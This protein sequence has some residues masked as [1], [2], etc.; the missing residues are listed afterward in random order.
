MSF[1]NPY[2]ASRLTLDSTASINSG[3]VA[4]YPL[5]DETSSTALDISGNYH[6]GTMTNGAYFTGSTGIGR[7][8]FFD[9]SNDYC[10]TGNAALSIDGSV[11]SISFW[12]KSNASQAGARLF[13][14]GSSSSTGRSIGVLITSSGDVTF[15]YRQSSTNYN[16]TGPT[17]SSLGSGWNFAV[18]TWDASNNIN[19]YINGTKYTGTRSGSINVGNL[20]RG[21]IAER[22]LEVPLGEAFQGEMQNVRCWTVELSQAQVDLLYA[23][24]WSGTNYGDLWPYSPPAAGSMT[25][26]STN[27]LVTGLAAWFPLTEGQGTSAQC[28][29][30][31][32]HVGTLVGGTN[33][34]WA[35]TDIGT[36]FDSNGSNSTGI[37]IPNSVVYST[38]VSY[39]FW[40]YD[41]AGTGTR[42]VFDSDDV[43]DRQF[44]YINNSNNFAVGAGGTTSNPLITVPVNQWTH[45]VLVFDGSSSKSYKNGVFSTTFNPG[46]NGQGD[47]SIGYSPPNSGQFGWNGNVQNFRFYDR[48]LS[49]T[50]VATLYHRPWEGIE[51]G[52]TFHYDP[53]APASMLPLTSDAIN[54][55]QV[56]WWPLTETDD[57]AS[58]AADISGSGNN[59]TQV[60]GVLSKV[61]RLGGVASFDGAN[62]Y[63]DTS[64]SSIVTS[65]PF[66]V[67]AWVKA[68]SGVRNTI[69]G[70]YWANG[71]YRS[72][73]TE[74][75]AAGKM[76]MLC[77]STGSYQSTN[78]VT[79]TTTLSTSDYSHVVFVFEASG[80]SLYL[81]GVSESSSGSLFSTLSTP[82]VDFLIGTN[83]VTGALANQY[84]GDIANIRV[85]SRALTADEI[86]SI[87]TN[88]WLGSN[89]KLASGST[90]LYNYIFRT[91]R[92]RR[93]G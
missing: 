56:G 20:D 2:P 85:W 22:A 83:G 86:W 47:F 28:I 33:A 69:F 72:L 37:D 58:G 80:G 13:E 17:L 31:P 78:S 7:C 93:L 23:R 6:N 92:F 4:F 39:S 57:Y 36:A 11:G 51:Y 53:P 90:P 91:E 66:T 40:V 8:A 52:D 38:P 59:G 29:L 77:S 82:S 30:H 73:H 21:Y 41:T 62:D 45:V 16:A 71:T 79:G 32:S 24:P 89:Y 43:T 64:S 55:D 67:S 60:N 84:N 68:A 70:S 88:P 12:F 25:V 14:F 49:A 54:T 5:T 74:I 27:S 26:D 44:A 1:T 15:R 10:T 87:Y 48:A 65:F 81:N 46:S 18:A 3:L 76:F 35:N 42:F 19:L 34:G 9:G 75:S 63:I 61:S 50:E